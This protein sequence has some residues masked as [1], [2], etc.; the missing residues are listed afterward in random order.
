MNFLLS[1]VQYSGK[2]DAAGSVYGSSRNLGTIWNPQI[3]D[4]H[5]PNDAY[6]KPDY[7][8]EEDIENS[9]ALPSDSLDKVCPV[10]TLA[11]LGLELPDFEPSENNKLESNDDI[12][13]DNLN[14]E[15]Q[16]YQTSNALERDFWGN[17]AFSS[18]RQ[19]LLSENPKRASFSADKAASFA[20]NR[21]SWL[22]VLDL[23]YDI[24]APEKD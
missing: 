7:L 11:F 19:D 16:Q 12:H 22:S 15:N 1:T 9:E 24:P 21:L 3:S 6:A 4:S 10:D 17:N 14:L 23:G 5:A 2:L 13:V 8:P 20:R 18:S